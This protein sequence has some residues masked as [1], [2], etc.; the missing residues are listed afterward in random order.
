MVIDEIL[1]LS[2]PHFFKELDLDMVN[3]SWVSKT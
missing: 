1:F 2:L 3:P